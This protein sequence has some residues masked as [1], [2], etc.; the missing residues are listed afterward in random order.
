MSSMNNKTIKPFSSIRS[1]S[2]WVK[3]FII[4]GIGLTIVDS[5]SIMLE[6]NLLS[7]IIQDVTLVTD[8]EIEAN[9]LRTM[10]IAFP[11][12]IVMFINM[13]LFFI[14]YY[15]AYRNLPSLGG[16]DLKSSPRR[17]IIY[18]FIPILWFYKPYRSTVEI[19]K[20]S[21]TSVHTTDDNSR[22]QMKTPSLIKIWW[23][24]WILTTFIG[25]FYLRALPYT[26]SADTPS[27]ILG[28]DVID[29]ITNIPFA[30]SDILTFFLVKEIGFRQ[31]KKSS[32]FK[33]DS[34]PDEF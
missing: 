10:I 21:D 1:I 8:E 23:A 4:I 26:M 16:N 14:W 9:D 17:A 11:V 15:K 19:W 3:I 28:L 7:T 5:I 34:T 24:F 31:E 18:F 33:D 25:N 13:I 29:L 27:A 20:V 30:I 12:I 2:K 22:R 6:I 32:L